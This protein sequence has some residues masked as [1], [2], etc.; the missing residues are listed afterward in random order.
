MTKLHD[1]VFGLI[2]GREDFKVFVWFLSQVSAL[3]S[4][5]LSLSLFLKIFFFFALQWW[6]RFYSNSGRDEARFFNT[7]GL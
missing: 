4:F 7:V 2:S 5:S 1:F 3:Y 6:L